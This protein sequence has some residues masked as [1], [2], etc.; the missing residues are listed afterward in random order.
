MKD[1]TNK[2]LDCQMALDQ[3]TLLLEN[4]DVSQ[5]DLTEL[6]EKY[7]GCEG[8]IDNQYKLWHDLGSLPMPSPSPEM[9][10]NFYQ[11]LHTFTTE[12]NP[13]KASFTSII[14][15]INLWINDWSVGTKWAMV[16]SVFILGLLAGKFLI[17]GKSLPSPLTDQ[18]VSASEQPE[19]MTVM[20][21]TANNTVDR[22][23]S[24]QASKNLAH[25]NEKVLLALNQALLTDPN[26]N[27]RLSAIE[28]LVHFADHS[29]VREYLIKAIPKQNEP[30][31][32]IALA[33]AMLL[34]QES[35]SQKA[36]EE[37]LKSDNV[38]SDVKMHLEKS[39]K[40]LY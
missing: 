15:D 40:Q 13:K 7:P 21:N 36:W 31:V 23:K 20:Y 16:A 32:Q 33:D 11:A 38:E 6:V 30:L 5:N 27:V 2:E 14:R 28:S 19:T 4:A 34:L 26:I 22:L 8:V 1:K 37:L 12:N 9:R 3:L 25:P 29:S 24:V 18:L 17:P 35:G 10:T 39:L